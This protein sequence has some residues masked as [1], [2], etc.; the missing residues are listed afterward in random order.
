[1]K[2]LFIVP[3][4]TEGASN[5]VRVEQFISHL[6]PRGVICKVRP[7]V[8]RRFF[9][10]LYRP[11]RY[12]EKI[13]WF[14]VGTI[15]RI[16]DIIRSYRYDIVFIHREAYPFGGPIFESILYRMKKTII[17]D[18]DDA[19]FLHSTSEHNIYIERF[20][21]P[22]KVSK[23]IRMSREVIV[24]N[25]YL[26]EYALKFN[27]N[28]TVIPS[29]ID[30]EKYYPLENRLD[31]KDVVIGWIGSNTTKNFL[32]DLEDVFAELSRRYH[33]VTFKFVGASFYSAKLKKV[34][35][36]EWSLEDELTSLQN[37]DIGIMP[38]PDN[39]WTRGKCGFKAIL[40]MACAIPVVA[41]PVGVNAKI[42][43]DG[44]NGYL[45]RDRKGWRDKLSV[46][47]EDKGLREEMGRKG[48]G[49]V[50]NEYSLNLTAPFFYDTLRKIIE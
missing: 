45:V 41:S 21:K 26:R 32:Y 29:S 46:L 42:V 16:F 5:R 22:D 10:I 38:M 33:N 11:H 12:V 20:K 6:E 15:N 19:I 27:N 31:R 30:T 48:R 43:E 36:E 25:D 2:V 44:V 7:F 34:I 28:V 47:I 39:E 13:F 17:F 37:F 23:I 35:N 18:F 14:I 49:K 24:G 1:M 40:Y 50:L 4:P 3:Y 9:K 8:N